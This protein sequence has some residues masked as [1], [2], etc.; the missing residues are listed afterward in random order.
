MSTNQYIGRRSAVIGLGKET[1]PGTSVSPTDWARLLSMDFR[2]ME[3][4]IQNE[5]AMGR[6]EKVNEAAVV[7]Q[8][9]QGSI[10]GKVGDTTIGY[11]LYSIFGTLV[12]SDMPT[13]TPLSKTTPSTPP[14]PTTGRR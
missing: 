14:R 7:S 13:A 1:T 11:L 10:E 12:T 8:W 9:T 4:Q 6:V 3:E 5:S 2:P